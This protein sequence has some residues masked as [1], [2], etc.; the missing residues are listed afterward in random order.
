MVAYYFTRLDISKFSTTRLSL[1]L[2]R[3]TQQVTASF[4]ET[5]LVPSTFLARQNVT[6][7]K[8]MTTSSEDNFDDAE[9]LTKQGELLNRIAAGFEWLREEERVGKWV[10]LI[11]AI[12]F[13]GTFATA[14]VAATW[15]VPR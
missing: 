14:Y 9:E 11:A 4:V 13:W 15:G 3:E 1:P 2:G 5:L 8:N 6:C 12:L 10:G 7:L